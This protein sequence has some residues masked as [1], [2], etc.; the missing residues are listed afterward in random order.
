MKNSHKNSFFN[1]ILNKLLI[2]TVTFYGS[3][4]GTQFFNIDERISDALQSAGTLTLGAFIGITKETTDDKDDKDD[5][6]GGLV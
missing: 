1:A 3:M 4:I 2:L 6:P 5:L